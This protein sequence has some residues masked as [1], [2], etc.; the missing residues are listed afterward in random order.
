[1]RWLRAILANAS[2]DQRK[3]WINQVAKSVRYL[4]AEKQKE[5]WIRWAR[6]HLKG[7]QLGQFGMTTEEE[8]AE[9]LLWPLAFASVGEQAFDLVKQLPVQQVNELNVFND[10]KDSGLAK[11]NPEFTARYLR[12][13][14]EAVVKRR[15]A[16]YYCLDDVIAEIVVTKENRADLSATAARL[17]ALGCTQ[18]AEALAAKIQ[19]TNDGS[20]PLND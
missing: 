16:F 15:H 12:W 5:V 7:C 1:V 2:P 4:P 10:L 6:E 14:F 3:V 8:F 20:S 9:F 19:A 13:V 11:Q 18:D 17:L